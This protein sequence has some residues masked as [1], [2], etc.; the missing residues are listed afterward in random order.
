MRYCFIFSLQ[1]ADFSFQN[2]KPISQIGLGWVP[3]S[4]ITSHYIRRSSSVSNH[5][6]HDMIALWEENF[7]AFGP[8][9]GYMLY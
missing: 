6:I 4:E 3:L 7:F 9:V 2:Y 1:T 5:S 8:A